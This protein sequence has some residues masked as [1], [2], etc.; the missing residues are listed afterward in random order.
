MCNYFGSQKIYLRIPLYRVI[1]TVLLSLQL[2][3]CGQSPDTFETMADQAPNARRAPEAPDLAPPEGIVVNGA[4]WETLADG[5]VY[6]DGP[7][8][9]SKGNVF[10]AEVVSNRLLQINSAGEVATVDETTAMTMG[11]VIGPDGLL[12][13]CRNRDAQIIRYNEEGEVAVLLQ[14]EL[15]PL[16]NKPNQPGEFCNDLAINSAGGIWFTD[17]INRSVMYLD[18]DGSVK[19]VAEGFRP[20]GIVLS[21]DRQLISVT[22]SIDSVLHAFS[23]GK[24]GELTELPDYFDPIM[25]VERIG[26]EEIVAGRP[27]SNG[28]TVDSDGRFYVATFYGIQL[29]DSKGRY[30]GVIRAPKGFMSNLTFG[31]P[32]YGWLY[33]TGRVGVYRL[34]M[35]THGVGW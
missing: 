2:V 30:V 17:R 26:A 12:Y 24:E 34:D 25:T 31:G 4:T 20:N 6:T 22:D 10:F 15:S 33:V 28:M 1:F 19:A 16:P 32:G 5:Y 3:Q 11:L 14:G 23:V 13:G 35:Q 27:G 8:A 9:D 21:A 7:A 18:P 29:F